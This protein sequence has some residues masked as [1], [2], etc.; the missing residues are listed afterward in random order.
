[1]GAVTFG[2][3]DQ[4]VELSNLRIPSAERR[5]KALCDGW[6]QMLF[7]LASGANRH[8]ARPVPDAPLRRPVRPSQRNT[9]PV[10]L[11]AFSD[12]S[13]SIL[14]S[15]TVIFCVTVVKRPNVA[16][17]MPNPGDNGHKA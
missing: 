11:L 12:F 8:G 16:C 9:S 6:S 1:M 13:P 3:N 17:H 14:W 10:N 5:P 15:D 2:V 7:T 4:D